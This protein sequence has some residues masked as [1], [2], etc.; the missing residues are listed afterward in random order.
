MTGDGLN[1]DNA[2]SAV[3]RAVEN[4]GRMPT[5]LDYLEQEPGSEDRNVTLPV[6]VLHP[7]S[8]TRIVDF[9]TDFVEFVTDSSGNQ[10]GR[11]F[12][13]EYRLDLQLD[14]WTAAGSEYGERDL[15]NKLHSALYAHDSNGPEKP[16]PDENG[17]DIDSVWRVRVGDGTQ[18]ND[19][20]G[21][22]SIRRWRQDVSLWAHHRFDTSESYVTEVSVPDE[23]QS[24]DD[25]IELSDSFSG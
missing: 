9:N 23:T 10:V 16:L 22:P 19:L 1:P 5:A 17:N 15:G 7:L 13:A 6:L 20:T 18:A 3:R 14:I 21:S 2:T 11:V 25:L 24:S 12:T 4:S 8:K